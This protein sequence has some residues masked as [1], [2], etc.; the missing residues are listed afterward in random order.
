VPDSTRATSFQTGTYGVCGC[1][2]AA[3]SASKLALAV[4]EDSTLH[5]VNGSDASNP[6]DRNGAW[7][8][9]GRTLALTVTGADEETWT[10]DKND[11]CLHSRSGLLFV[12]P[13]RLEEC[14]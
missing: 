11:P 2:D 10:L 6:I 14:R 12:P 7:Q 5:Y 4:K 9:D 1:A 3:T 8:T 13:C